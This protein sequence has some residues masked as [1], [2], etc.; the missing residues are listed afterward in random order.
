MN[1][2]LCW[3]ISLSWAVL[4]AAQVVAAPPLAL[5]RIEVPAEHPELWPPLIDNLIAVSRQEFERRWE[6][7]R[8]AVP[9]P[10]SLALES[11]TYEA[12]LTGAA[13]TAG[14]GSLQF[15]GM[16]RKPDW[17]ALSGMNLAISALTRDGTTAPLIWGAGPDQRLW[18]YANGEEDRLTCAWALAGQQIADRIFFDV[19][20]PASR[21]TVLRLR[22]PANQRL[23]SPK[24]VIKSPSSAGAD[25]WNVWEIFAGSETSIPLIVDEIHENNTPPLVIYRRQLTAAIREDHLRFE[26]TFHPEVLQNSISELQFSVPS[27]AEIYSVTWGTD[28]PLP[29]TTTSLDGRRNTIRVSLPDQQ[30]GVLRQIR[31]EGIV[32][33]RLGAMTTLP[34]IDLQGAVFRSG[35]VQIS[36]TLPLILASLRTIGCRQDSP[37][38]VT[39][40]GE[41]Y[42]FQQTIPASQ[43]TLEVRRPRSTLHAQVLTELR[44]EPDE[45]RM[46]SEVLWS[47]SSGSAFQLS[48]GVP[49]GWEVTDIRAASDTGSEERISWELI[50]E[51]DKAVRIAIE[52]LEALSPERPRRF[53]V[54]A[55][56]P[57]R[58]TASR[59]GCPYLTPQDCQSVARL[60]TVVGERG[61]DVYAAPESNS[62]VVSAAEIAAPWTQFQSWSRWK[63]P[64][65]GDRSRGS[66][67]WLAT[68]DPAPAPELMIYAHP[69]PVTAAVQV[70]VSLAE[71]LLTETYQLRL[72]PE[73]EA[74]VSHVLVFLTE[75][76]DDVAWT[77]DQP[78]GWKLVASRIPRA[79]QPHTQLPSG[80]ELWELRLPNLRAEELVLTGVRAKP[81]SLPTTIGLAFLPQATKQDANVRFENSSPAS[82]QAVARGLED[83]GDQRASSAAAAKIPMTAQQWRYS[84]PQD[85][86]LVVSRRSSLQEAPCLAEMTLRSL[87]PTHE[88][89]FSYHL[90]SLSLPVYPRPLRFRFSRPAEVLQVTLDGDEFSA[91]PGDEIVIPPGV[92]SGTQVLKVVYRSEQ[93]RGFLEDR[94]AIPVLRSDDVVWTNFRWEFSVPSEAELAQEPVGVRLS[95]VPLPVTWSERLFGPL[96]RLG[97]SRRSQESSDHSEERWGLFVPWRV[98]SWLQLAPRKPVST[99]VAPLMDGGVTAPLEWQRHL[100]FAPAPAEHLQVTTWHAGRLRLLAWFVMLITF[101]AVLIIRAVG[102]SHRTR[103]AAIWLSVWCGIAVA[104]DTPLVQLV[105]GVIAGTLIG[106]VMP[107]PWLEWHWPN[108]RRQPAVPT[109]STQSFTI[110][111][112]LTTA[113][114]FLLAVTS[115]ELNGLALPTAPS[116]DQVVLV[117]VDRNGQPT[118]LVYVSRATW[119]RLGESA[120]PEQGPPELLVQTADYQATLGIGQRV[121]M[122]ARY[123]VVVVGEESQV[124]FSLPVSTFGPAAAQNCTVDGEQGTMTSLGNGEGF[125]VTWSR[126]L[127]PL[128]AAGAP[129]ATWHRVELNWQHAWHRESGLALFELSTPIAASARLQIGPLPASATNNLSGT[130]TTATGR[131]NEVMLQQVFG[132]TRRLEIPWKETGP[133]AEP[134]EAQVD[135][136]EAWSLQASLLD[137]RTRTVI[138]PRVG[139]LRQL[140]L[141]LPPEAVLRRWSVT[142]AAE[143]RPRSGDQSTPGG[144]LEFHEPLTAAATID[145]EYVIPLANPVGEFRWRGLE[146]RSPGD[147]RL[148]SGQR[149]W[150]IAAPEEIRI[151]PQS[152]EDSGLA[153]VTMET[154]F[155]RFGELLV[156]RVPQVVYQAS[157]SAPVVFRTVMTAP[158]RQLLLWQQTGT[159]LH[160]R[161]LWEVEGELEVTGLPVYSHNLSVDRRLNIESVVVKDGGTERQVRWSETRSTAG[162][163]ASRITVFLSHPATSTQRIHV[164]ASTP[165]N[166]SAPIPLPNVRCEDSLLSGGRL[167]LKTPA[168][169][170]V[171]FAG[172]RGLRK[173]TGPEDA[174]AGRPPMERV[175]V[176]DQVDSD[177]RATVR[178][179][180]AQESQAAQAVHLVFSDDLQSL[181]CTSLWRLP[182]AR[183]REPVTLQIPAPWELSS[184]SSVSRGSLD[185]VRSLDGTWNVTVSGSGVGN[186]AL[187]RL[188]LRLQREA[189][190][191]LELPL[192]RPLGE[193]ADGYLGWT[194]E[195]IRLP[196][197]ALIS[198]AAAAPTAPPADWNS[199]QWEE[200]V[201]A[202]NDR[203]RWWRMSPEQ[204]SV[205]L[206]DPSSKFVP[207]SIDWL[208]HHL[209]RDRSGAVWGATQVLLANPQS[210]LVT[211][212]PED[213]QFEAA[214][215][216][217]RVAVTRS[218]DDGFVQISMHDGSPFL[219]VWLLWQSAVQE[220]TAP[221]SVQEFSWPLFPGSNVRQLAVTIMPVPGMMIRGLGDWMGGDWI[222]RAFLRLE[223]GGDQLMQQPPGPLRVRMVDEF[224]QRYQSTALKLGRD[225]QAFA[226][227]TSQRR[228]RWKAIV[229][230]TNSL[231]PS[232]QA[233]TAAASPVEPLLYQVLIDHADAVYGMLPVDAT[234]VRSVRIDRDWLR[235]L[236][237]VIVVIVV[238]PLLGLVIRPALGNW[239][240]LHPEISLALLGLVWWLCLL[241]S[242]VGFAIMVLAVYRWLTAGRAVPATAE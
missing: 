80:G 183:L 118:P 21:S 150:A 199:G 18:I 131:P 58:M 102:L 221:L 220:T 149:L 241:P 75:A 7:Q 108:R 196:Q 112:G 81:I 204:G 97:R 184:D 91:G 198:E 121:A 1:G 14:S 228:S 130:S 201:L 211:R 129:T 214:V 182:M 13:F 79:H 85:Q 194:A 88:D 200:P 189:L 237:A 20:V 62:A 224:L 116:A 104:V 40:E 111:K 89:N 240:Q 163:G 191:S 208:E 193:I 218:E 33:Q 64:Q 209:Y 49:S 109:G 101:T 179:L 92:G 236:G 242:I 83:L 31:L 154:A 6:L 12:T 207:S 205:L 23:S 169:M 171:I 175:Q 126:K 232:G 167:L 178:I 143:F 146:W 122:S 136:V 84:D 66:S 226:S 115:L 9:Q 87:V 166:P 4:S 127:P 215:I 222:D 230:R 235:W 2:R 67:L 135:T 27:N 38:L 110:P 52:L 34:Q 32:S 37:V 186:E 95:Q 42:Q 29:W 39:P 133:A 11:A 53:F 210:I 185:V 213:V 24:A 180:T 50:E 3:L 160:D 181:Q 41:T 15:R 161:L 124:D 96:S 152:L 173:L 225:E 176:F 187:V 60:T 82:V 170:D 202:E 132:F 72:R 159:L 172:T 142:P 30:R 36:V 103:L 5:E 106:W 100:A 140:D 71:A 70:S 145:L 73:R 65:T 55:R 120:V 128:S 174:V 90:A 28:A 61:F 190:P 239:L 57:G 22:L 144:L 98:E 105:G 43:V 158:V 223:T 77:V 68:T 217:D 51:N 59:F 119:E 137:V 74:P 151:Q 234:E 165:I 93:T 44:C 94:R 203:L 134:T 56:L 8:P 168:G 231:Q 46:N 139:A 138:R 63:T 153:P 19:R 212:F 107:R 86:L 162:P 188:N 141:H 16:S 48:M 157:S 113:T 54:E 148:I 99:S 114:V 227:K 197:S 238:W 147:A 192:P 125:E 17:V 155:P 216:D 229:E 123:D 117:P 195:M 233:L 47:S 45:W 26:V 177:W 10:P 35:G 164:K 25:G 76:G 78:A 69:Q 156:D 219:E 206:A